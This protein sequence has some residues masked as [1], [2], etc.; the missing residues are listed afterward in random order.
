MPPSD[1]SVACKQ[2]R[3]KFLGLSL[4]STRKSYYPQLQAQLSALRESEK[5]LR[6]LADNLPARICYVDNQ[7][8]YRFV[9]R[10]FERAFALNREAILE[11]PMKA[12]LGPDNYLKVEP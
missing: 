10:E 11:R 3:E 8:R 6:L 2:A 9:N 7:K 1:P 4:A 12:V 5:R